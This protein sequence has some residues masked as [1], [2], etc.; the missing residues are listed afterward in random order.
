MGVF[1]VGLSVYESLGNLLVDLWAYSVRNVRSFEYGCAL[2]QLGMCA[3]LI[4]YNV[5]PFKI[6]LLY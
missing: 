3:H 1:M 5:W 2:I 4:I 6:K